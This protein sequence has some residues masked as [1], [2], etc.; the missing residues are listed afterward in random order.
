[1][2]LRGQRGLTL[3]ECI[4]SLVVAGLVLTCTAGASQAAATL[5][6][7]ARALS[8]T[9]DV[10]RG[11]L[12]HELGAP[13]AAPFECPEAYRCTVTRSPLTAVADRIVAAVERVDGVAR[14]EL[15]SLAP[16][17]ACGG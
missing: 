8:E 4:A 12:E 3:V 11:L 14:E 6:R 13:C 9:L 2:R 17:P 15:R 10:A 7:R 16:A 5:V 1:M